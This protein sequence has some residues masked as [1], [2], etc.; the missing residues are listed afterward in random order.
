MGYKR[1]IIIV[2]IL[3]IIFLSILSVALYMLFN[4]PE[5]FTWV[6]NSGTFDEAR[7]VKMCPNGTKIL[8][9]PFGQVGAIGV[10]QQNGSV[11]TPELNDK[12]RINVDQV[13]K[14]DAE[15]NIINRYP[16]YRT[17]VLAVDPNNGNVWV[18]LPNEGQVVKLNIN[19][20]KTLQVEGFSSPSSIAI[21]PRDSSLWV[22]DSQPTSS[23]VHLDMNGV[24]LFRINT[25]GFFSQSPHQVV[26]DPLDGD[27]WY[28]G[29]HTANVYKLSSTGDL[30]ATIEGFD[31]PVSVSIHPSDGGV[32]V[33]DYSVETPGAVVRLSPEG[34]II[35][36]VVLDNPP[37]VVAVNPYDG[38]LWVGTDG[39]MYKLSD[40]GEILE[41]VSGFTI[42]MSIVFVQTDD[43]ILTRIGLF[44]TCQGY[45]LNTDR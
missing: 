14:L 34:E 30:L 13:V 18:G 16:G 35:R 1:K 23:L 22:A 24:E 45:L 44:I 36:K 2:S 27:V 9:V 15:G 17:S 7:L 12:E 38:T 11:W 33:A 6:T 31:R 41:I 3:I 37:N 40:E 10:D 5:S 4:A 42:P 19:G 8:Q 29:F 43:N 39:V 26:V 21:D 32:W 25:T 20:E 28:T